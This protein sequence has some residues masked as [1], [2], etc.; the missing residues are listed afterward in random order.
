MSKVL[1]RLNFFPY[2]EPLLRGREKTTTFRVGGPLPFIVGER[3]MLTV[4]WG[5][6]DGLELHPA[7]IINAYRRK[8]SELSR[9]DFE[10]ESPDC[11]DP[12]ATRLVLGAIYRTVLR[13]DDEIWVVK[14][15]H[16]SP[17]E[18]S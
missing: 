9:Q 8:I 17:D 7:R 16:E 5:E 3:V 4:G 18:Q 6:Q 11:R 14:F 13:N 12:E 2:Y 1:K 10:G 15:R